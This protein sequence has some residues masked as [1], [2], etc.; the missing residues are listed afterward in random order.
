M[1]TT[2]I[3]SSANHN[4]CTECAWHLENAVLMQSVIG[5]VAFK[6]QDESGKHYAWAQQVAKAGI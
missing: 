4:D 1:E 3:I 6:S 2:T 5:C